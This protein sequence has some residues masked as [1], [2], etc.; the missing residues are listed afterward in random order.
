MRESFSKR[1]L[2]ANVTL[3]LP[4]KRLKLSPSLFKVLQR[5]D[6]FFGKINND[7]KETLMSFQLLCM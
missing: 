6:C 7:E 5:S 3:T 4:M 2:L 1:K